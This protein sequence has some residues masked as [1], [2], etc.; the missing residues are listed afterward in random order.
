MHLS[1]EG[2][3]RLSADRAKNSITAFLP[4]IS[5]LPRLHTQNV[6]FALHIGWYSHLHL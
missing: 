4:N 5:A 1:L 6:A 2:S 3:L